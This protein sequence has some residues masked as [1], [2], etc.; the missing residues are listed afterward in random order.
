M[1]TRSLPPDMLNIRVL[2]FVGKI[3]ANFRAYDV[4]RQARPLIRSGEVT[5]FFF[6]K[7]SW[8]FLP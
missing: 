8:P 7:F 3:Y 6:L 2:L 5:T 4:N 1:F